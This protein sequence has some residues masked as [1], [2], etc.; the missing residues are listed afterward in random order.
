MI[1]VHFGATGALRQIDFL[2]NPNNPTGS[3]ISQDELLCFLKALPK[4]ILVVLDE[5]YVEFV[6]SPQFPDS[7]ALIQAGFPLLVLRSF[8]KAWGLA[9]LRLGY[10]LASEGLI[11]ALK[12]QQQQYNTNRLAHSAALES[13]KDS[14]YLKATQKLVWQGLDE[15]QQGLNQLGLESMASEANFILFQVPDE[16]ATYEALRKKQILVKE[17]ARFGLPGALRVTVGLPEQNKRFLKALGEVL[18]EQ[19]SISQME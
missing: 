6:R 11:A 10:G 14:E 3:I 5:A 17:M 9:G 1:S 19:E 18:A 7:P 2:A 12:Q 8:S 13:L 16:S 15:L 4:G